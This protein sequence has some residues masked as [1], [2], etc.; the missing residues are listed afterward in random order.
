VNLSSEIKGKE[1]V[2]RRRGDVEGENRNPLLLEFVSLRVRMPFNSGLLLFL[3]FS[4]GG[5]YEVKFD[6]EQ[7]LGLVL[8]PSSRV[9]RGGKSTA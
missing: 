8:E 9:L 5:G 1:V 2:T 6:A 3:R 7:F 4:I